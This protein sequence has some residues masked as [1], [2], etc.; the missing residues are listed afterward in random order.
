MTRRPRVFIGCSVPSIEVAEA[1]QLL[2]EYS[3]NCQIW[4]Q[5]V[6]VLSTSTLETW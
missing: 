2:L 6:M 4:N 3:A 1:L 5:G